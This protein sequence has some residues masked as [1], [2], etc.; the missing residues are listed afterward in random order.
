LEGRNKM[1]I[2]QKVIRE[3]IGGNAQLAIISKCPIHGKH[4][5]CTLNGLSQC[6]TGEH[7]FYSMCPIHSLCTEYDGDDK[8]NGAKK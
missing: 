6:P 2:N 7:K 5:Y 1:Q 8:I 4:P 3:I